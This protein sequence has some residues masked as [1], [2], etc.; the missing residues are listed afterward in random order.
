MFH[1]KHIDLNLF[2]I[3]PRRFIG[4]LKN[5]IT[6]SGNCETSSFSIKISAYLNY[7]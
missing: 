7:L 4:E 6:G 5:V 3:R 1:V 2:W